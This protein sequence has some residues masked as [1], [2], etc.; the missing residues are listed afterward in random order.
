[1]VVTFRTT[2]DALL[3]ESICKEKH[4]PGRMIPVPPGIHGECGLA[5]RMPL[6]SEE[7]FRR[8]CLR[9]VEPEGFFEQEFRY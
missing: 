5:W 1:M 7:D 6:S 9:L 3:A 8:E 4:L 2:E